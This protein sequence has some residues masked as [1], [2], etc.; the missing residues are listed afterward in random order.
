MNCPLYKIFIFSVFFLQAIN[1]LCA[2][3][4]LSFIVIDLKYNKDQGVKI[5]EMQPGSYSRFSGADAFGAVN[6]VPKAYCE[7]L[8]KHQVPVYF[9]HPLFSKTKEEFINYGWRSVHSIDNLISKISDAPIGDPDNL[10]NFQCFFFSLNAD[11][12]IQR[13]PSNFPQILFLDRAILP[14]SQNKYV[15]NCLFDSDEETKQ[16][17]PHWKCYRKGISNAL[18]NAITNDFPGTLIVIKPL[19]STMGRGV[20]ILEKKDL[21]TTLDYIFNSDKETLLSDMER[22][23]SHY[24][25]DSSDYF[26]VEEFVH[27]DPL[28]LGPNNLP[29]D[30]TMRIMAVLSYH[31]HAANIVFLTEYWYSPNKPIDPTYTLIQSHKAKGTFFCKVDPKVTQEV[32]QQLRSSILKIYQKMLDQYDANYQ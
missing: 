12:I 16:L 11:P 26:I 32:K 18:V 24:A 20:I 6:V 27:S 7:L 15:M 17:R 1:N 31:Q 19:Q 22:S 10:S 25:V 28:Y 30:C 5:C 21:K 29:Y 13:Y 2:L 3:A 14:F 9:T 8:A 4:D 23:Y